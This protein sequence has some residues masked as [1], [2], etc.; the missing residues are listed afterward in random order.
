VLSAAVVVGGVGLLIR[1]LIFLLKSGTWTR[2]PD[3]GCGDLGSEVVRD[4]NDPQFAQPGSGL[5]HPIPVRARHLSN[6]DPRVQT[7]TP[8]SRYCRAYSCRMSST[9]RPAQ[10]ECAPDSGSSRRSVQPSPIRQTH[11]YRARRG[12]GARREPNG[13]SGQDRST[14]SAKRFSAQRKNPPAGATRRPPGSKHKRS[15]GHEAHLRAI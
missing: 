4:L 8:L 11:P 9:P 2:A 12:R 6:H 3:T 14:L 15:E 7:R 13:A 5:R 10:T 1:S